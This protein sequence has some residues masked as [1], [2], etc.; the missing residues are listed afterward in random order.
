MSRRKVG[1]LDFQTFQLAAQR[2]NQGALAEPGQIYCRVLSAAGIDFYLLSYR[3]QHD[4]DK[5]ISG[6][7]RRRRKTARIHLQGDMPPMFPWRRHFSPERTQD[8]SVIVQGVP[9]G[10]PI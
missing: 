2:L 6:G 10:I 5:T 4:L 3:V 9:C 7:N 1:Q 8:S